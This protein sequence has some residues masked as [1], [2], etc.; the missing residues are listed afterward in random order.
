MQITQLANRPMAAQ[1]LT[2]LLGAMTFAGLLF[3]SQPS[4]A[5]SLLLWGWLGVADI[6]IMQ[7]N[8]GKQSAVSAPTKL[9]P[10][11][12]PAIDLAKAKI[13]RNEPVRSKDSKAL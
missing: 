11:K 9:A 4:H 1:I 8:C 6:Q 10:E 5:G 3:W 2:Q 13:Q 12:T 7:S